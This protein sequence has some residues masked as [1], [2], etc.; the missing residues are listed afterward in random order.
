MS[1]FPALHLTGSGTPIEFCTVLDPLLFLLLTDYNLLLICVRTFT[2]VDSFNF[3][4]YDLNTQ[5]NLRNGEEWINK[6]IG[7][8]KLLYP[9]S[10]A[11]QR[12]INTSHVLGE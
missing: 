1:H 6:F 7:K 2:A 10:G 8:K 3:S 9:G 12:L 4:Y 11:S 5:S